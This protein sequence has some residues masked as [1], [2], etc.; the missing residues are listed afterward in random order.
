MLQKGID[1][2]RAAICQIMTKTDIFTVWLYVTS[3]LVA[4]KAERNG[5]DC[6]SFA[7]VNGFVRVNCQFI[8]VMYN[9]ETNK[10]FHT[11]TSSR[12]I[13]CTCGITGAALTR[14]KY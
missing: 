1:T 3:P 6:G 8:F 13:Y 11:F 9:F 10:Y 2:S 14:L 12:I 4:P 5:M 7:V